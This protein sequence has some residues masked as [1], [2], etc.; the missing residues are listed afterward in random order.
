MIVPLGEIPPRHGNI[1][2]DRAVPIQLVE[3]QTRHPARVH[4][5][6][7]PQREGAEQVREGVADESPEAGRGAILV[8]EVSGR[9]EELAQGDAD[10]EVFHGGFHLGGAHVAAVAGDVAVVGEGVDYGAGAA[11]VGGGGGAVFAF[12]EEEGGV[13]VGFLGRHVV[14]CCAVWCDW[15]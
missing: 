3:I 12:A 1:V 5:A 8:F 11:D 10:A 14:L 2:L 7:G 4:L 9:G 6:L 13:F 15:G